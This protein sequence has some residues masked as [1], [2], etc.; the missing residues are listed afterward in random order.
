M[1]PQ[2]TKAPTGYCT[3]QTCCIDKVTLT[4][5]HKPKTVQVTVRPMLSAPKKGPSKFWSKQ[6]TRQLKKRFFK[7]RRISVENIQVTGK[8]EHDS[9][10]D[11]HHNIP[12]R[13]RQIFSTVMKYR[14]KR[15]S[16]HRYTRQ[17]RAIIFTC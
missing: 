16:T 8:T 15:R 10:N 17:N 4:N 14:E 2:E 11:E 1:N 12:N 7:R 9:W 13:N 3:R 5:F 6:D